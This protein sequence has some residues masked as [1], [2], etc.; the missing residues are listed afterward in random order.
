MYYSKTRLQE[1]LNYADLAKSATNSNLNVI[2]RSQRPVDM[3]GN[4][5]GEFEGLELLVTPTNLLL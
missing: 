3:N 5:L 4:L 2:L 1:V